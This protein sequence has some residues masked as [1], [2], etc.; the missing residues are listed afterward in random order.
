[1]ERVLISSQGKVSPMPTGPKGGRSAPPTSS[2][3][4]VSS[5]FIEGRFNEVRPERAKTQPPALPSE[6]DRGRLLPGFWPW[7]ALTL[8][9]LP[10]RRPPRIGS[11]TTQADVEVVPDVGGRTGIASLFV[12]APISAMGMAGVACLSARRGMG[13]VAPSSAKAVMVGWSSCGLA[14]LNFLVLFE[15]VHIEVAV[16]FEPVLVGL[17]G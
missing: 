2:A 7:P 4:A 10:D 16:G 17:D 13:S 11:E 5:H 6:G 3:N 12:P 14:E 15:I 1:M 8:P 9:R